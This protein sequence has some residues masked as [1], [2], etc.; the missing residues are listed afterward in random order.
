MR[1]QF[2]AQRAGASWFLPKNRMTTTEKNLP[3]TC[4]MVVTFWHGHTM[5]GV[6]AKGSEYSCTVQKSLKKG[7]SLWLLVLGKCLGERRGGGGGRPKSCW[8]WIFFFFDRQS[9]PKRP[10]ILQWSYQRLR[11]GK[12]RKRNQNRVTL[13]FPLNKSAKVFHIM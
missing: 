4:S 8:L 3:T 5:L 1:C 10:P 11:K 12:T 9:V 13:A 6:G 7:R 2:G